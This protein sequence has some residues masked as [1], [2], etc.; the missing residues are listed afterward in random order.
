[1]YCS[2]YLEYID[3]IGKA[4]AVDKEIDEKNVEKDISINEKGLTIKVVDCV[5]RLAQ[6][7]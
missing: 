1:M 2:I 3:I 4:L 6:T 5:F 7:N